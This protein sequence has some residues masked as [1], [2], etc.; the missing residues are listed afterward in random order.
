MYRPLITLTLALIFIPLI[1]F[2][3]G[4]LL[5]VGGGE[6]E[7]GGWSDTPYTWALERA[8]N[9]S[10]AIIS[11]YD[12]STSNFDD[13]LTNLGATS[14]KI[15][16][17]N[18]PELADSVSINEEIATYDFIFFN[19]GR[20][21]AGGDQSNYYENYK[22]TLLLET[23]TNK[24]NEGGVIGGTSDGMMVLSSIMFS[25]E[26]G[27]VFPEQGWLDINSNKFAL[28]NDFLQLFDGFVFDS[29][30]T[31]RGRIFRLISFMVNWKLEQNET[32]G[33]IGVDDQTALAIDQNNFA[34]VY[35]EGGV[36]IVTPS[37]YNF[38][39]TTYTSNGIDIINL[40]DRH[41]IDLNTLSIQSGPDTSTEINVN[42]EN[43]NYTLLM[44][45]SESLVDNDLMINEFA[46]LGDEE[47]SI[48]IVSREDPLIQSLTARLISRGATNIS[49]LQFDDEV[50]HNHS[51]SVD[52]RN[53]IRI[54]KKVLF[55]GNNDEDL[56]DLFD[57][58]PTGELLKNHLKRDDIV[59]AF[60]G[61]D[62]RWAGK[63]MVLN[64][65]TEPEASS[66]NDLEFREG[67]ALLE[68]SAVMPN[69]IDFA[70]ADYY[71]NTTS[72]IP[73]MMQ[74]YGLKY[75]IYLTDATYVKIAD[76]GNDNV[77][78]S[79]GAL[80]TTVITN[81]SSNYEFASDRNVTAVD[82]LEYK[83]LKGT[84]EINMGERIP[85]N[86]PPYVFEVKYVAN[87][88][89]LSKEFVVSST[90]GKLHLSGPENEY[91]LWLHDLSG[92]ELVNHTFQK[93]CNINIAGS[94]NK[95]VI[96]HIINKETGEQF[97]GKV[98]IN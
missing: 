36:T 85:A 28:K 49:V 90:N 47:D 66:R 38:F 27:S 32:I 89:P 69:T 60:I 26:N 6:E 9:T 56:I 75:G 72:A 12:E 70:I 55:A 40:I 79:F 71:E 87:V 97:S 57:N 58:G 73:Y 95:L 92:K 37:L 31:E 81:T 82:Q 77:M 65:L 39:G 42:E 96:T 20:S 41:T 16:Q 74:E 10:V 94:K 61:E 50:N 23:I 8:N 48:L 2:S 53:T 35:G 19:R 67:L 64:H 76:L 5:L 91:M 29:H 51:D 45:G 7:E 13:Y 84:I 25:A 80:S 15:F 17:I 3:Q 34:T 24:F 22:G 46:R 4:K 62:S 59:S 11:F 43:G 21:V 93:E 14:V 83:V 86:D 44:S 68:T 63:Y 30:L 54:S 98:L 18:S 33:G 88:N 1:S 52:I 78:R